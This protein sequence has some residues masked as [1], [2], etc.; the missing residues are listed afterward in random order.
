VFKNPV[1]TSTY[2]ILGSSCGDC[3]CN[4]TVECEPCNLVDIC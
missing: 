2:E 1:H 3:T 4:C